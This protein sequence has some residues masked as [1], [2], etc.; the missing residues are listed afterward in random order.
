MIESPLIK[1]LKKEWTEDAKREGRR[2]GEIKALMTVLRRRFGA[3]ADALETEI[4][5]TGD[6][7]AV[8]GIDRACRHMPESRVVSQTGHCLIRLQPR[9]RPSPYTD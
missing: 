7:C 9:R 2:E 1:E 5:A 8:E 6:D 3:K 4:R